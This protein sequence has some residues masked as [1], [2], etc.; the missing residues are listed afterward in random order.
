MVQ[1][2]R[3]STFSCFDDLSLVP[4]MCQAVMRFHLT[5]RGGGEPQRFAGLLPW[6]I[7]AGPQEVSK[8]VQRIRPL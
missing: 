6:Q 1:M 7:I 8:M 3:A 2:K 5:N 4:A